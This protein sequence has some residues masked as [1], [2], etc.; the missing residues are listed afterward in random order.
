MPLPNFPEGSNDKPSGPLGRFGTILSSVSKK[1]KSI[2]SITLKRPEGR[3]PA[4]SRQC[5]EQHLHLLFRLRRVRK[6]LRNFLPQQF[7]ITPPEPVHRHAHRAF[8]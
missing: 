3:A 6:C 1:Q 4:D 7:T 5:A 8:R 2:D